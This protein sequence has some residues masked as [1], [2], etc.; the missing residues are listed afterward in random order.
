MKKKLKIIKKTESLLPEVVALIGKG[1][2]LENSLHFKL[3]SDL[4]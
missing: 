2:K 1:A 4:V 3:V